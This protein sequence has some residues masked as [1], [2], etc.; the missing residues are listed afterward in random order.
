MNKNNSYTGIIVRG[1]MKI[2]TAFLLQRYL[3]IFIKDCKEV[4]KYLLRSRLKLRKKKPAD[5]K[6]C[7]YK[8]KLE[9]FDPIKTFIL[10]VNEEKMIDIIKNFSNE[11]IKKNYIDPNFLGKLKLFLGSIPTNKLYEFELY[12]YNEELVKYEEKV[13]IFDIFCKILKLKSKDQLSGKKIF[14]ATE[15]KMDDF[16]AN[17]LYEDDVLKEI[18]EKDLVL[19]LKEYLMILHNY[20]QADAI[21]SSLAVESCVILFSMFL[22]RNIYNFF[23]PREISIIENEFD[24][25][26]FPT[27]LIQ[28][29]FIQK[30]FDILVSVYYAN[31]KLGRLIIYTFYRKKNFDKSLFNL[32]KNFKIA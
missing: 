4:K 10:E 14:S 29:I 23:S 1:N 22:Q 15:E 26:K 20:K 6:Q 28:N 17:I 32:F 19:Y 13:K 9:S 11:Q 24:K 8:I 2:F 30:I 18:D 7:S 3:D 25:E 21:L 27:E 16:Y 5:L 31:N 12:A